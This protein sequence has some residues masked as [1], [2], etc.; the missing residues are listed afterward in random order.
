M[1]SSVAG[2]DAN[3]VGY[4]TNTGGQTV[5]VS[6][7]TNNIVSAFRYLSGAVWTG[8]EADPFGTL[9][10]NITSGANFSNVIQSGM[11]DL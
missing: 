1:N 11:G 7:A 3:D 5:G 2:D 6:D 8:Y 10:S 9:Q 4:Y